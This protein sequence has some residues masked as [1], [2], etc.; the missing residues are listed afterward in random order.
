M[1][2]T[3]KRRTPSPPPRRTNLSS[4]RPRLGWRPLGRR[5]VSGEGNPVA[6][7]PLPR[8][9]A[10]QASW[11][12]PA[13]RRIYLTPSRETQAHRSGSPLKGR[14]H[15]RTALATAATP[16]RPERGPTPALDPTPFRAQLS[17]GFAGPRRGGLVRMPAPVRISLSVGEGQESDL[18]STT[19]PLRGDLRCR[20]GEER[21]HGDLRPVDVAVHA[22]A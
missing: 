18:A 11:R 7:D 16:T 12:T 9:A 17:S 13:G 6:T 3:P 20:R 1:S 14:P 22:V 10:V 5:E 19:R 21:R 4:S 2:V 8:G 15:G